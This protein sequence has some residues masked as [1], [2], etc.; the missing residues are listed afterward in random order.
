MAKPILFGDVE[1][2]M[3][4]QIA[5]KNRLKPEQYLRKL[6]RDTYAKLK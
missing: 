5:R 2:A 4:L 6:V 1:Y 3:L